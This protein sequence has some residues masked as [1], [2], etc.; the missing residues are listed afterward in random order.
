MIACRAAQNGSQNLLDIGLEQLTIDRNLE[1]AGSNQAILPET[2]DECGRLRC[3]RGTHRP[4]DDSPTP[5][6]RARGHAGLGPGLINEGQPAG[7][8]HRSV[9]SSCGLGA[10]T[11]GQREKLS[12]TRRKD[13]R[14]TS[15]HAQTISQRT[16]MAWSSCTT[17]W[18]CIT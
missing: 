9:L 14:A 17:L 16:I 15:I 13:G 3:P 5:S 8:Q 10:A 6:R 1:H 2:G 18:Q 4:A 11:P 12:P 7:V